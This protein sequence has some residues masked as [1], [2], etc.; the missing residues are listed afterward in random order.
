[1]PSGPVAFELSSCFS[2]LL[3]DDC[4]KRTKC[5]LLAVRGSF[6]GDNFA[7]NFR[8]MTTNTALKR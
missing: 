6:E 7:R 2:A 3:T 5:N 4:R 1:M 8:S